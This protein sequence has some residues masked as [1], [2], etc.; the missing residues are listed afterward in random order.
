M[1]TWNMRN[2]LQVCLQAGRLRGHLLQAHGKGGS[3]NLTNNKEAL[4]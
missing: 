1:L 2:Y 3:R 4:K